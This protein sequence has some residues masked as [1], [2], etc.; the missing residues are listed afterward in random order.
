M[1]PKT[2]EGLT[3]VEVPHL[4][5]ASLVS[6]VQKALIETGA[7]AGDGGAPGCGS[8]FPYLCQLT[9]AL[10]FKDPYHSFTESYEGAIGAIQHDVL[11]KLIIRHG[12]YVEHLEALAAS[13]NEPGDDCPHDTRQ[14]HLHFWVITKATDVEAA[15]YYA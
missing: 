12:N 8:E 14:K 1:S 3:P 5:F 11:D 13:L 10:A 2:V 15:G 6:S 4:Y 9:L 7:A